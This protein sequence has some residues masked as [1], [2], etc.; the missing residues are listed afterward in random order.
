MIVRAYYNDIY[1]NTLLVKCSD[2]AVETCE[3]VNRTTILYNAQK[4]VVGYNIQMPY[5]SDVLG[6]QLMNE[7]LLA[8]INA[9]LEVDVQQ[10]LVHDFTKYIV[11]GKV[12]EC[13]PHPDSDHLHVCQ[14]DVKDEVL[15][16]VCGAHNV[17]E[18]QLVVVAKINAVMPSGLLIKHSSLRGVASHGML[19]SAY[20]LGIVKEKI[21]GIMILGD[22]YQVGDVFEEVTHVR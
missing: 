1:E 17:A 13:K 8:S 4:A 2:D 14:V 20:E 22:S 10:T 21:K 6:L 19:C 16:I 5:E 15:Q 9:V 7:A 3:Q 12:L 18:N 11:V